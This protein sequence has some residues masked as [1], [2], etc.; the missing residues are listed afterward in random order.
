[1]A[2]ET[3]Y[4]RGPRHIERLTD[5]TFIEKVELVDATATAV[6][7]AGNPLYT[8]PAAGA[9]DKVQGTAADGAAASGNPV[10][11]GGVD[12]SANVQAILVDTSGRI[13]VVGA[14]AIA[15]A[16]AGNPVLQGLSDGTNARYIL[17]DTSGRLF[18]VGPV[19]IDG[20]SA[21]NPLLA[22]GRA[23]DAT[24]TNVSADG[25]AQ[26][27]WLK[28]NGAVATYPA[29][30]LDITDDQVRVYPTAASVTV[31]STALEASHVL[32]ASAGK[33]MAFW[34]WNDSTSP[35]YIQLHNTASVPAD[36]AVPV[37]FIFA[38]PKSHFAW[39][40]PALTGADFSTGISVCNSSTLATK[41][42]GSADCWFNAVTLA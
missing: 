3:T 36:T 28:L 8:T 38:P 15:A 31:H 21:G 13:V 12:G 4:E 32:K 18:V 17:G 40:G 24:P 14:S 26:A 37:D 5:K 29:Y 30:G 7:T 6:G 2:D 25:D 27:L 42:I 10:Q 35:Q 34:G 9:I 1:M 16:V 23:S 22:G 41:T 39:I 20:V 33:L 19:A 11:I